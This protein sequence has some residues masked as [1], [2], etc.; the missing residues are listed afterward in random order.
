MTGLLRTVGLLAGTLL[1]LVGGVRAAYSLAEPVP[2]MPP[3]FRDAACSNPCWQGIE[4]GHTRTSQVERLLTG[5]GFTISTQDNGTNGYFVSFEDHRYQTLTPTYNIVRGREGVV[6]VVAVTEPYCATSFLMHYGTPAQVFI[7]PTPQRRQDIVL[8]Y[9][10][11][12]ITMWVDYD[13]RAEQAT[14]VRATTLADEDIFTDLF[15]PT[16]RTTWAAIMPLLRG[17]HCASPVV[18]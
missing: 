1:M 4:P 11:V 15:Q 13:L 5:A 6:E 3:L 14:G 18:E 7:S 12:P 9:P 8:H 17:L 16:A 10:Q 2:A